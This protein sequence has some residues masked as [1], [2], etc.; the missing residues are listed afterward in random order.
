M[1]GLTAT[2]ELRQHLDVLR[3]QSRQQP[4]PPEE[5]TRI[6]E[7]V[8]ATMGGEITATDVKLYRELEGLARFIQNARSEI[9]Q[10]RP[11][12]I[13]SH[14]IPSATDELDAVVGA[15]EEATGVILDAAEQLE[16]LAATLPPEQ[17]AVISDVV[18][19]VY[20]AC[21]FQD[22]TGQRITKV[23]RTLKQIEERV[24]AMIAAFGDEIA[25]MQTDVGLPK[26]NPAAGPSITP[27]QVDLLHGP[28]LPDE[29]KR[30]A[31]IDAILASFG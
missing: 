21:N 14:D 29:A 6:V 5:V 9:A 8:L 22:V 30:Q 4:I 17:A 20:E 23:V 16:N 28:A 25:R 15:T 19:R 12:A 13:S 7:Q 10:V 26:Y 27:D 24:A 2:P 18:T 11:D 3:Q 31:E 1:K